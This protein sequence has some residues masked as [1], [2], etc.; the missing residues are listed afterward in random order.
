MSFPIF[1]LATFLTLPK[2]LQVTYL[3]DIFDEEVSPAF[4]ALSLVSHVL[5]A[6]TRS[7]TSKII[8]NTVLVLSFVITIGCAWYIYRA[9]A[10]WRPIIEQE[11]REAEEGKMKPAF[12]LPAHPQTSDL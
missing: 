11:R 12:L 2:Q 4:F 1:F 9:M 7:T 10:K 5:Q 6:S 3:G 8:T